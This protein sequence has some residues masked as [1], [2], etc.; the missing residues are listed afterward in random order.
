MAQ[1]HCD[2]HACLVMTLRYPNGPEV[3]EMIADGVR[4]VMEQVDRL[5]D[6][7]E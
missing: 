1:K 5:A 3:M 2:T 6:L 7:P 4:K